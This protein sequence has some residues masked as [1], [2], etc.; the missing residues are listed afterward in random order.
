MP[1]PRFTDAAILAA[2]PPKNAVDPLRLRPYAFLVEPE[3]TARGLVEDVATIFLTNRECPFRCLMCDLWE[4]TTDETVPAGAIPAQIDY[5]LA[6]LPTAKHVK[7]YNSGNFF[8]PKAIP[9]SDLSAIAE[10]VREYDTVIVENHPRLCGDSCGRFRDLI[11]T[12]LEIALGLETIHPD[13][14]PALNKRMT[15]DDFERAVGLLVG[16]DIA[17]RAFILLGLPWVNE[18]E[19]AEWAIRSVEFA[20]S[21]GV[22]CCSVIPTRAKHGVLT[23]LERESA[24]RSPSLA[25]LERVA[26]ATVRLGRGRAFV[27]LWDAERLAACP[28]CAPRRIERMRTLNFTQRVPPAVTCDCSRDISVSW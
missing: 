5:A 19:A 9:R 17:V 24:F 13:L 10:R 6:R 26:E 2:R 4:N 21:I 3:R 23:H 15:L 25:T 27:D 22:G 7:L 20:F 28:D 11:G 8:D 18:E 1:F 16:D 14:L 12:D